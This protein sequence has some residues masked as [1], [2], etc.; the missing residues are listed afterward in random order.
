MVDNP[1]IEGREI[2]ICAPY[3]RDAKSAAELLSQAIQTVSIQPDLD[4]TA[5]ALSSATG[6][7]LL[8][9]EALNLNRTRFIA[10]M[11]DQPE[12]SDIPVILLVARQTRSE[13]MQEA[14]VRQSLP[15]N[16]VV[17]IERPMSRRS[18]ISSVETAMKSRG[19]QFQMRDR[20]EDLRRARETLEEQVAE[21]T[22][23]LEG[24][25]ESRAQAEAALRQSQKMEAVGQLTG[26]IAHDFNN[27]LTGV[28]GSLEMLKRR[29]D[30]GRTNDLAKYMDAASTSAARAAALT[31][32]L[33]AFARRQS[34]DARP[35]DVNQLMEAMDEL[36][37]RA[38]NEGIRLEFALKPGLP[39]AIVDP[40][41]LENA[42]LNLAINARDAMPSGGVLTVETGVIDLGAAHVAKRPDMKPGRYVVVS[43]SDIGVGMPPELIEKV[44]DPFF[45]TKPLGQGTGLGLSMVYGFAQQSGGQVRIHSQPG[46]GTSVKIYLPSTDVGDEGREAPA[47]FTATGE[48]QRVLVV[49][50][51]SA[52]RMLVRD[53]LEEMGYQAVEFADPLAAVPYLASNERIDLM[54]S[55]VGMPGMNGRELAETARTSRPDLPILF[56]TGYA[57]N[58]AIRSEFLGSNMDMIAKPF[59]LG[60]LMNKIGEMVKAQVI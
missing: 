25:M 34:L 27:M 3:G 14:R 58:A 28:I 15:T 39:N 20:L 1:P 33:L 44:F 8:T 12:W 21:R 23:A 5:D 49:E 42:I 22:A 2:L 10:A 19:R 48:G 18:L 51:D 41:Q 31:Q 29:I 59:S 26:G 52:V 35:V 46:L 9:E 30:A 60:N 16:N 24:E 45:T 53:V 55:D 6:V 56:I 40:N 36:L 7:L 50:D 54:I 32:R 17:V 57:E 38:I 11:A 47:P 43:V 37:S 13:A 4:H